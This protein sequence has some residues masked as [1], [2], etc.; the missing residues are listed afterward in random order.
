MAMLV[1][2]GDHVFCCEGI[3]SAI[4]SVVTRFPGISPVLLN[5]NPWGMGLKNG[6]LTN[7]QVIAMHYKD[8]EAL[9]QTGSARGQV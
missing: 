5:P 7:S 8:W 2:Y 1:V 3:E 6:V 4:H 9:V